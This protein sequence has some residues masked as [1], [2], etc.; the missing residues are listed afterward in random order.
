MSTTGNGI[1]EA[2][3]FLR[4]AADQELTTPILIVGG[5]TA[6]YAATLGA[7]QAGAKVCLVQ[8]Q[9]VL[10]GQF[11]TQGLPASD[12]GKLLT[13]YELIPPD[14][15]DPNQLRDSEYFALSRSQRQFRQ[16]QRQHQP[17]AHQ[18]LQNPG[19]SWVSHLSVTPTVAADCL[20]AAIRPFLEQGLLTLIPWSISIRVLMEE[21]PRRILGVQFKDKQTHH[22][23]MV[24]AQITIE[25]TDLGELLEL[26]KI[27]SRVGQESRS[28]TQEAVL[29][30]DPRPECQQA[31]TFC[32]VVERS[33][34]S[35]PPLPA[36]SGYD[37]Q[38]W[39]Q[40]C[41]FTDEFWTHQ[42]DRWQKHDFYDPDGMFRYRRLYRSQKSDTVHPGD[43]TVLNWATSPL[44]VNGGPPD[45]SA[46]LGCGN[47]YP[48]GC[49]LDVSPEQRQEQVIRARDRTQAYIH[50]LQTHGHPELKPRGD[51]TWTKDGIALEPYIREARRGLALTT[52]RHE[53]MA[54]KFFPN[55]SRARTFT[56]S[57]GIGQYHYLDVHPNQ[58]Q[59]H[60]ELGDGHDTLPFTLPL[61]ALI[62]I[63]TLG[64]ILSAKSIGTTHITNA[65][66]RM[67]PMEWAIGEA[68]GHLAA[69]ALTNGVTVQDIT[70]Q[71]TLRTQ[72][73]TSLTHQ[74]IPII[75][76]N[77]VSHVDPDFAAIQVLTTTGFLPLQNLQT[78]NFMPEQAMR[79]GRFRSALAQVLQWPLAPNNPPIFH[80]ASIES[81]PS[82]AK[83][84][85]FNE[86]DLDHLPFEPEQ[87]IT[88]R[89][90][91][92]LLEQ[93]SLAPIPESCY[94]SLAETQTITNRIAARILW[95]LMD[96]YFLSSTAK[97]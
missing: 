88:L 58:A 60:V 25:A 51:L 15:R 96:I 70:Q 69:F 1:L 42:P 37:H 20:N 14:R 16:C 19:G 67:H 27:P 32:A 89:Q 84:R 24:W 5:S 85:P 9:L 43:I 66:Y 50:Y 34:Q 87:S 2:H 79:W 81:A 22:Q 35:P 53:D 38:P 75:W 62:P 18:I 4:P 92:Q 57:V 91:K 65:A 64:L 47:D 29:P 41:D 11:T 12:D 17:V 21:S 8:P 82:S 3:F 90:A 63:D 72:F 55:Q 49:L 13:P 45:P 40:S 80:L 76:F 10:G 48:F 31:I 83:D 77:D 68:G 93:L 36:P 95:Y 73:Q 44:G 23:F 26:G 78:L 52:I 94:A 7:L 33:S 59:G 28:Q 56:D 61:S 86:N 46:P 39:L 54:A 6:A 71:P 74:G 97:P 30:E